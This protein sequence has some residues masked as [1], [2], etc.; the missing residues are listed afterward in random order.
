MPKDAGENSSQLGMIKKL[1]GKTPGPGHFNISHM[2]E[3]EWASKGYRFV[4]STKDTDLK[5]NKNPPV[6]QYNVAEGMNYTKRRTMGGKLPQAPRG[7][8]FW[9]TASHRSNLTPAPGKYE[10]GGLKQKNMS[11]SFNKV[12]T[13]TRSAKKPPQPGPGQ[14]E[15]NHTLTEPKVQ[16]YPQDK[17][18][19]KTFIDRVKVQKAKLPA[20]GHC[21]IPD[22][23]VVNSKGVQQH[24]TR[25]LHEKAAAISSGN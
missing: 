4:K 5:V 24:A 7:C 3:K 25:L 1:A 9:D 2:D 12:K 17:E 8:H 18:N 20:P 6:G 10:L 13:E 19:K 21:G 15:V 14:Y 11:P 16:L 23:K 22:S